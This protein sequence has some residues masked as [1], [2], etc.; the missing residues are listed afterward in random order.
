M[1][2]VMGYNVITSGFCVSI[3][4][5]IQAGIV[6]LGRG[7]VVITITLIVMIILFGG[8]GIWI[9]TLVSELIVLIISKNILDKCKDSLENEYT[10]TA[11]N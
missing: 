1:I 4:K 11:L 7:V 2:L 10:E 8:S 5:P 3:E 6:S 9:A